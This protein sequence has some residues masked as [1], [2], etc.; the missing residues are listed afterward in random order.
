MFTRRRLF[1]VAAGAVSTAAL[2]EKKAESHAN[3]DR[4]YP[5]KVK[6]FNRDCGYGFVELRI[7]DEWKSDL[8]ITRSLADRAGVERVWA[9]MPVQ[10]LC[11][12]SPRG[13]MH[14]E[15]MRYVA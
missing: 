8:K 13:F 1:G 14:I 9:G 4:W 12:L 10:V 7:D 11:S 6:W 15:E 3:V 5:A 2:G